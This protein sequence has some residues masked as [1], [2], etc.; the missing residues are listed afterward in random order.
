MFSSICLSFAGYGSRLAQKP[1]CV[2]RGAFPYDA[3]AG[4][5]EAYH[6]TA[7]S[8]NRMS[9]IAIDPEVPLRPLSGFQQ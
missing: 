4:A 3:L 7:E 6:F 9:D 8:E 2:K 1:V 5:G